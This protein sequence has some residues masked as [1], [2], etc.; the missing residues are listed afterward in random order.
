[1]VLPVVLR[2]SSAR[3]A[4]A[5]SRKGKVWSTSILTMP[6]WTTL[7]R[8]SAAASKRRALRRIGD[9]AWTG[10]EQAALGREHAEID[11]RHR[12]RG[13]AVA[14]HHAKRCEAIEAG[15]EGVAADT[16]IDDGHHR[17]SGD[18]PHAARRCPLAPAAH[19]LPRGC[20]RWPPSPVRNDTDDRR[21]QM[22]RPLAHDKA[23]AAGGRIDQDRVARQDLIRAVQQ[24]LR[25]EAGHH[26]ACGG[27]EGDA[28]RQPDQPI[29]R[30]D[31]ALG[32][33]SE[34][35]RGIGHAVALG[36]IRDTRTEA[37]DG[38][39]R[40]HAGRHRQRRLVE[41]TAEVDVD[42]VEADGRML[43][44]DLPR[45]GIGRGH[46]LP[47]SSPPVRRRYTR[48]SPVSSRDP[49]LTVVAGPPVRR[50]SANGRP[51]RARWRGVSRSSRKRLVSMPSPP[52]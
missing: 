47:D 11:R 36:E 28:R 46:L 20:R 38:A 2:D 41:A 16:V 21:A 5:A 52:L 8:S 18:V 33:G 30:H 26:H 31:A 25:G 19:G 22:L 35:H 40:F 48:G 12:A 29:G 6:F 39:G 37:D 15:R 9:E 17:A 7:N 24:V 14:H 50:A 49:V 43:D 23:D 27:L 42:E 10:Q 45:S 44:Q 51:R 1:M 34:R 4:S 3:C 13:I 32:I